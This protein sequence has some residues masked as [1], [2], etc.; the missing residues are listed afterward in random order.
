MNFETLGIYAAI[1]LG[2]TQ[3]VKSWL[4]VN[5]DGTYKEVFTLFKRKFHWGQ[6]VSTLS[7][8]LGV[9]VIALFT[10]FPIKET[11]AAGVATGL[12]ASGAFSGVKSAVP[13]K[14]E[15]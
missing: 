12:I 2:L 5:K 10:N 7:I 8:G 11:I 15:E 14:E 6:I 3:V 9:G 1:V 13:L 4:P